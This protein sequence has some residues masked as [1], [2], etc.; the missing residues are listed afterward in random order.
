MDGQGAF[1]MFS[2][3]R[4]VETAATRVRLGNA[5]AERMVG[6]APYGMKRLMD[7]EL[8]Q[9]KVYGDADAWLRNLGITVHWTVTG[10]T[11]ATAGQEGASF[12]TLGAP[13][14]MWLWPAAADG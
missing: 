4:I 12:M 11:G 6:V 7:E 5:Q 9:L 8:R 2:V 13:D 1:E 10:A 14:G 3:L